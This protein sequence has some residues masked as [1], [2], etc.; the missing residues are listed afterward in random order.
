MPD[1]AVLD[2]PEETEEQAPAQESPYGQDNRDLPKQLV[3]ALKFA[4]TEKQG[5][6]KFS[7]RREV[8]RDRKLRFYADGFQH[9]SWSGGQGGGWA[10]CTP[11]GTL[12]NDS[13]QSMQCPDFIDDYNVFFPFLRVVSSVGCNSLPGVNFE[14]IDPKI[15]E[16]IDKAKTAETYARAFDR[17]ND[18][19]AI[20]EEIW[21]MFGL[22][23][24]TVA[25]TRTETDGQRFGYEDDGTPKTF[26]CTS[27]Y[28]CL[29]SKVPIMA[30]RF[31]KNFGYCFLYDDPDV[32]VAKTDYPWIADE[33]KAGTAALSESMYER[34]ARLGVLNGT[35]S[36]AQ[37]G[38]SLTHIVSKINAFLRPSGFTGEG[39]NEQ[40][41]EAGPEDA[42]E[43]G[44]IMTV[45]DKLKQLFPEGVRAVFVGDAFAQA[46]PECI[47][48]HIAIG[49]PYVGDGMSRP[50]FMKDIVV[51]QDALN[52]MLNGARGG[53][54]T[55]WGSIWFNADD[56]DL[57]ALR[58]QKAAPNAIRGF[59]CKGSDLALDKNIYEEKGFDLPEGF[60]KVVQLLR[61]DLPEF[62]L[63][64]LPAIQGE[65]MSD[66]KT[67]SGLALATTQAKGQLGIM[68]SSTQRMFA[69]IRYQSA[70]AA[71]ECEQ[72]QGNMTIPGKKG[73][74]NLTISMDKLRKGNFGCYP[75]EDSSFPE[76]TS[77]QR[78][79]FMQLFTQALQSPAAWQ[80]FDNPDNWELAKNLFGLSE[81]VLIPS[82]ARDKQLQEI[83]EMLGEEPVGWIEDPQQLA[84]AMQEWQAQMAQWQAQ[85]QPIAE[86]A[87][88]IAGQAGLPAPPSQPPPPQPNT[89]G[90]LKCS[91]PIQP[92]DFN[93]F[94]FA[95]CQEW[96]SSAERRK[97]DA[98]GNQAGVMNVLLHALMHQAAIPP[99]PMMPP[100]P[101]VHKPAAKPGAPPSAPQPP[102]MPAA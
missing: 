98:N 12:T 20:Q 101:M 89:P 63:A 93:N 3:N 95:K 85:E 43:D 25:W 78:A 8:I 87:G 94:E 74:Q 5:Q 1:D 44:S 26:Q 70:L 54:D 67:A 62:I 37:I 100:A 40:F 29:E 14:P 102:G 88:A 22:S 96:L 34:T 24:R 80:A 28:G 36:R 76:S 64:A 73:E 6:E 57:D 18:V 35:K 7:R 45:G 31:D 59:K 9:L 2:Q 11:G 27:I 68:F 75:D 15:P 55:G 65:E 47:D 83:E 23:G 90:A 66:N 71:A 92:L 50:P 51:P 46:F 99:P 77:Q 86:A 39:F 91:V 79:T 58:S 42:K 30:R 60:F 82:L 48:D 33:I 84:Q 4:I 52:D 49:F 97:Q 16:D 69:S 32:R 41:A 17:M 10:I 56:E 38:D 13:G 19:K 72:M 21:R 61:A 53:Y 81:L